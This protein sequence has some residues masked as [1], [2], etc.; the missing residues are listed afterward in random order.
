M[1]MRLTTLISK[2]NQSDIF[3]LAECEEDLQNILFIVEQWCRRWRLEVDLTKTN[4]MYLRKQRRTWSRFTFLFDCQPV[5]YCSDYK[6]LG[7]NINEFK[8]TVEKHSV[9]AGRALSAIIT[10]IMCK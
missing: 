7:S 1:T 8:I 6:Y 4:I 3:C 2:W 5:P 10:I 9:S